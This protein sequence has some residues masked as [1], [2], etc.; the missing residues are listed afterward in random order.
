MPMGTILLLLT[1][2][3]NMFQTEI[4]KNKLGENIVNISGLYK[5]G[6][7]PI[8]AIQEAL[9]L[10]EEE[11]YAILGLCLTSPQ[12]LDGISEVALKKLADFCSR[13]GMADISNHSIEPQ[14]SRRVG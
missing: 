8:G 1:F 9:Q 11:A 3:N 14:G 10:T 4:W 6:N 12:K 2:P 7:M 13:H 5:E